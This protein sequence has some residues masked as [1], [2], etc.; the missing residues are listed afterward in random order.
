[1]HA[2]LAVF[3]LGL[4]ATSV[5]F[6]VVGLAARLPVW[7][8]IAYQ[9]LLGGLAAG[10]AATVLALVAAARTPLTSGARP[11]AVL[12]ASA[13]VSALT[14]FGGALAVRRMDRGPFPSTTALVLSAAGLALGAVAAWLT[15]ELARRLSD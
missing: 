7:G 15:V 6:D 14:L 11:A 9:D 8:E 2:V 1:M 3:S 12:R 4:L 10:G 5:L 13:Q